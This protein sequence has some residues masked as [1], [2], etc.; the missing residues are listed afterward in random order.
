MYDSFARR[1]AE[2]MKAKRYKKIQLT[3]NGMLDPLKSLDKELRL[4]DT[5][6]YDTQYNTMVTG[7]QQL[8]ARYQGVKEGH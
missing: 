6:L 3:V 7:L 4:H 8:E 1:I 2:E 5:W